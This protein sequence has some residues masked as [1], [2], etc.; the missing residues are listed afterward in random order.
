MGSGSSKKPSKSTSREAIN[1]RNIDE[2]SRLNIKRDSRES[3]RT[4]LE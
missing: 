4:S 3:K 2:E 1:P